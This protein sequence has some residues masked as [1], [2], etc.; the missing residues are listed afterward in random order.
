MYTTHHGAPGGGEARVLAAE[1][2]V[3]AELLVEQ[4]LRELEL[5]AEDLPLRRRGRVLLL[6]VVVV[7]V[8]IRC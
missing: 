4:G 6:W 1:A 8:I 5:L 3:L 7:V 2:L